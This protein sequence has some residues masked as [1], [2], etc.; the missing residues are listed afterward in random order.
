[1]L[2]LQALV[3][4]VR[5]GTKI[6]AASVI[7]VLLVAA[8]IVS[9]FMGDA[10]VHAAKRSADRE[11]NFVA[12]VIDA[13][14]SIRG[15]QIGVRDI[16]LA[17]NPE[18][19]KRAIEYLESWRIGAT[20]FAEQALNAARASGRK[21]ED[22]ERIQKLISDYAA[23]ARQI[24]A[25]RL[26]AIALQARGESEHAAALNA[27]A[28]AF[29]RERTLPIAADM[30][31]LATAAVNVARDS[32]RRQS[33]IFTGR[34]SLAEQINSGLAALAIL[35]LIG[36]AAFMFFTVIR[37]LRAL[38]GGM[39]ELAS[40]NFDVVPPGIDRKD[41]VGDIARAVS[42]FK[43]RLA[44]KML[45][46]KE[47]E[48]AHQVA[49][50]VDG[51]GHGLARLAQGD[52]TYRVG[53]NWAAE[54]RKI[55]DDFNGAI[56]KLQDTL[57]AIVEST[58]EV[59]NASAEISCSASD[60]SHR[61][62]EQVASLELTSASMD[63]IAAT[64]RKN[65]ENAQQANYLV[66]NT[67]E[68]AARGGE[69]VSRAVSAMALIEGSSRKIS[70]IISVIDKI[71][72]QTNLLALNAAVEAARAGEAGRG[73]AVVAAEVRG[74]AQRSAQAA[75]DIKTLIGNSSGQ[76]S[77]GV[78]L[79]NSAGDALKEIRN[80]IGQVAD[81]VSDITDASAEQAAGIEQINRSLAQMDAAN[82][83]NSVLVEENAATAKTLENQSQALDR[84][85][86]AFRL[87]RVG[88]SR[89]VLRTATAA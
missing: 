81:I 32:A 80:A 74:L 87:G 54:Y 29:A 71:A 6:V 62:D 30:E 65:A 12:D 17:A 7:G 1:M 63:E 48:T 60:L 46:E 8:I 73:F 64:V 9:Q 49:E 41:E 82:H 67:R 22:V 13:K 16:R 36:A 43:Q 52:L 77:E 59:S 31:K 34:I 84:R 42:E 5:I 47:A 68:M 85:M 10:A 14:D 28:A 55:R 66:R 79:V 19:I 38:T 39:H 44:E 53:E 89:P 56:G 24:E 69:V 50:V 58:R 4:D 61:T 27:R 70:E 57:A 2:F 72:R 88:A 45:L 11:Y 35:V 26:E 76:V 33:D 23:G 51:L 20:R 18:E 75:E 86:A 15:M 25:I 37:P 83:Q 3:L 40:G 78:Q 21:G